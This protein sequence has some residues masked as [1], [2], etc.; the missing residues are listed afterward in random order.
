[1]GVKGGRCVRLTS[2]PPVNRLSRKSGSLDVFQPYGTPRPVTGIALPL[3]LHNFAAP[4]RHNLKE[5]YG[6]LD[7]KAV[8]FG[9]KIKIQCSFKTLSSLSQLHGVTAQKTSPFSYRCENL[10]SRIISKFR[11]TNMFLIV[12][13]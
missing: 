1:V 2:P 4:V 8:Y 6:I 12:D 10:K 7:F 11:T 9:E 5:E 3:L 13:L